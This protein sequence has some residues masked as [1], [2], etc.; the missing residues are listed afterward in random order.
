[1]FAASL[2]DLRKPSL[3]VIG[4]FE[5]LAGFR[6]EDTRQMPRFI[7]VQLGGTATDLIHEK[8]TSGQTT[9]VAPGV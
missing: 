4:D 1:M 2:H 9:I 6:A 5:E 7:T 8:T 3:V